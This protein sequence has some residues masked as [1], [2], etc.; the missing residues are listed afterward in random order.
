MDLSNILYF[1]AFVIMFVLLIF[2]L[3]YLLPKKKYRSWSMIKSENE[4]EVQK[5]TQ[6]TVASK[7]LRFTRYLSANNFEIEANNINWDVGAKSPLYLYGCLLLGIGF[8]V[9]MESPIAMICGAYSGLWAPWFV[10][11]NKKQNYE[12]FTEEQIEVLVQ[13]VSAGYSI[14]QNL[15]TSMDKATESL[16]GPV[17]EKWKKLVDD[18]YTGIMLPDLLKDMQKSIPVKEFKMFS[19]VLIVVERN[20][21]DAS[22]T[23]KR[24]ADVIQ[25]NRLLKEEAKAELIQQRQAHRT[26]VIIA[27]GM[28]LFFRFA[29]AEQY[30]Q[31]MDL[32][33]GQGLL[34]ALIVYILWSFPKVNQMTRI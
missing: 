13:A 29:Q 20:G 25:S 10:L 28:V 27:I 4:E 14:T 31:L 12:D 17:K 30:K 33:L 3:L 34:I 16:E 15:T 9:L 22:P 1:G 19:D 2:L 7:R 5:K 21:G 24:I 32:P 11:N 23:M 26:N 8:G 18:Y 6:Q